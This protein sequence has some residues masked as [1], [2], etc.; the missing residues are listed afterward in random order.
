L[1][2]F[3]TGLILLFTGVLIAFIAAIIPLFIAVSEGVH[4]STGGCILIGFIPICFGSGE[5][6][7][8]MAII[9]IILTLTL[10]IIAFALMIYINRRT[11][12]YMGSLHR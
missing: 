10:M 11:R 8:H 5:Y 3:K 6:A 2:L 12:E 1:K 4:I 9:A 7:L